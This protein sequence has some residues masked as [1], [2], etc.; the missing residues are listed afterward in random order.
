MGSKLYPI[1]RRGNNFAYLTSDLFTKS[2][3]KSVMA[4]RRFGRYFSSDFT[5]VYQTNYYVFL[6]YSE[7]LTIIK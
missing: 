1:R 3:G 5:S 2:Q 4:V 7:C 6:L